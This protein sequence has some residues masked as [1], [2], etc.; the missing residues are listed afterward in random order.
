M[1]IAAYINISIFLPFNVIFIQAFFF[2]LF[3]S[4]ISAVS[5]LYTENIEKKVFSQSKF[6]LAV[7]LKQC[8][9]FADSLTKRE[10]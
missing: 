5:V 8:A 9:C 7:M 2:V 4:H 10:L 1:I 3:C 6:S